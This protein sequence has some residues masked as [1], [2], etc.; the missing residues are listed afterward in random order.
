VALA[1]SDRQPL[2]LGT[3]FRLLSSWVHEG[4]DQ[5]KHRSVVY[6][7]RKTRSLG[8]TIES[9]A[10]GAESSGPV[11]TI[12]APCPDQRRPK[13]S[14]GDCTW[15]SCLHSP[16]MAVSLP[17][18]TVD[19]WVSA[20]LAATFPNVLMWAPTQRLPD[21]WD[22]A[23]SLGEGT[24]WVF[25]NKGCTPYKT[26]HRIQ[27]DVAQLHTYRTVIN[28]HVRVFYVLPN[29]PW[30]GPPTGSQFVPDQAQARATSAEWLWVATAQ[31]VFLR[32]A[33]RRSLRSD[34]VHTCSGAL[35]LHEFLDRLRRCE[36]P[37][38]STKRLEPPTPQL[39]E[40][41]KTARSALAVFV[42][43]DDLS[44]EANL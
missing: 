1:D 18:R 39:S 26:W 5:R 32:L 37:D 29:P 31:A 2:Y 38:L 43:A 13:W 42:P 36:Y 40:A 6:G 8:V 27:V 15:Q 30:V 20:Y 12:G 35:T 21:N 25:E 28:P 19:S 11:R 3:F 9:Q 10:G 33:G 22:M 14:R 4:Q 24:V 34:Q 44:P 17:E 23:Q 41:L 16:C 7:G